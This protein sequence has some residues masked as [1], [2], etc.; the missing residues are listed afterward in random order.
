MVEPITYIEGDYHF[1][2]DQVMVKLLDVRFISTNDQITD[3]FTKPLPQHKL[4]EFK[5]NLNIGTL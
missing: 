2:R 3:G 1:A 4:L 5:R